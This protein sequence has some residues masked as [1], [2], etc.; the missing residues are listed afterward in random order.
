M[1]DLDPLR[2][3][4]SSAAHSV[5]ADGSVA[6]GSGTCASGREVFIWEATNGMRKLSDVLS[7][8]VGSALDGWTLTIAEAVSAD[9]RTIVGLGTNPSGNR[10]GRS[11]YLGTEVP[12]TNSWWPLGVGLTVVPGL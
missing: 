2:G 9:D 8:S 11:A 3:E 4:S 12:E 7:P 6:V 10:E 5:S 1:V